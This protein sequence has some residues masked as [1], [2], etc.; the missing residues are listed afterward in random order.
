MSVL[1]S[2]PSPDLYGSDLQLLETVEA[3]VADGHTVRVV[4]PATGPLESR[5]VARGASVQIFDFPVSRKS[6][7]SITGIPVYILKSVVAAFKIF[8]I[9]RKIRPNVVYANTLTTPVWFLSELLAGTPVI[10]HVHEAEQSNQRTV[11]YA[12]LLPL[13]LCRTIIVNSR[14]SREVIVTS[15]PRLE[16]RAKVVYNGIPHDD[17]K[18]PSAAPEGGHFRLALVGRLS[19]RKGT[20]IALEAVALLI[21]Q[22]YDVS[23][24]LYGDFYPGYEWFD[25]DLRERAARPD[26]AGRVHFAGYVKDARAK[27]ADADIVLVPSLAEPFGNVAVEAQLA[28]R[29]LIA[30]RVQ[31]LSEIVTDGETGT[32]CQPGNAK[33]LATAV[34]RLIDNWSSALRMAENSYSSAAERFGVER[35]QAQVLHEVSSLA[36]APRRSSVL[37]IFDG[38]RS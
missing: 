7:L 12:L 8:R 34:S 18:P 21:S 38:R 6:L 9:L 17:K 35:Y 25:A 36:V 2:H 22:Q 24:T 16:K 14:A 26:L 29:P 1:I 4:L 27:L 15:L 3:L 31:G 13:T 30:S 23:I 20:D 37:Q 19:P 5:I 28:N 32:L 10:C 11:R 33:E